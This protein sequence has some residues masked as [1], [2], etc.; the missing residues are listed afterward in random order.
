LACDVPFEGAEGNLQ[1]LFEKNQKKFS[2]L[3][4]ENNKEINGAKEQW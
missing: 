2:D 1:R 4:S 3:K